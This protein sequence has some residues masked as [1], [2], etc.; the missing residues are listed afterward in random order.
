MTIN[1]TDPHHD[2][3][4]LRAG[5]PLAEADG[6]IILL[7]G[8]GGTAKDILSL[9]RVLS[10]Q[11][12]AHLAPQAAENSWYP[13]SFL[14]RRQEN[15]PYLTSALNTVQALVQF[16]EQ[17]GIP[18]ERIVIAGFSQGACLATEFVVSYPRRY[19][20][21]VAFT[22]GLVGP[23]G[24]DLTHVGDL[25][26][27]PALLACGDPDPHIP[28]ERVEQSAEI[29]RSMGAEVTTRRYPGRPHTISP[30]EIE[31]GEKLVQ[32]AFASMGPVVR[33]SI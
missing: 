13:H 28:W 16:A 9:G 33:P 11:R 32:S 25:A 12:L 2:Q 14:S 7:H 20:A 10:G 4:I 30:E 26:G 17:A 15:E 19:A 27:T 8:R 5:A 24:T 22:G 6:A 21:L 29:L 1:L 31:L 23:L 18:A 3:P